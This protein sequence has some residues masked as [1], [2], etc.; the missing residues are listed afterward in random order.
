MLLLC[1]NLNSADKLFFLQAFLDFD[2]DAVAD[3]CGDGSAL[4]LLGSGI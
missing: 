2:V 4:E 3:A 1:Y